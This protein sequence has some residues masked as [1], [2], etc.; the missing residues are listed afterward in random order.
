VSWKLAA[1]QPPFNTYP[2][3]NTKQTLVVERNTRAWRE[4]PENSVVDVNLLDA[5]SH[6]NLILILIH[7]TL[8][9][10]DEWERYNFSP[11]NR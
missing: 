8:L 3:L 10:R 5:H 2:L 11:K 6:Q 7:T 1:Q 4:N 9:Y